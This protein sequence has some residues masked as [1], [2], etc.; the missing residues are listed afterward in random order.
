MPEWRRRVIECVVVAVLLVISTRVFSQI[1][2]LGP[3]VDPADFR[4]TEFATGLNF[5]VGMAELED[6]SILAAVS[7]DGSLFGSTSGSLVRL[8]DTDGDGIADE[9]STLVGNVPGG[10]LTTVRVAGDLVFTTGQGSGK[11]ISIYRFGAQLTD[12]LTHVGSLSIV[13][14]SGGWLHPHSTVAVREITGDP[15]AYELYFQLGSRT[16][17]ETT[18]DTATLNSTIGVSGS[19]AGDAIHRVTITDHGA[20]LT[21]DSLTQIATGL[22]NSAGFAFQPGTGDMFLQDNGIDGLSN[23]IEPHSADELNRIRRSDLGGEIE[24]FGFPSTYEQYRT[25]V[26]IGTTGIDPVVA[27]QPI[28]GS[29]SEGPNDIAFAPPAF[30]AALRNGIF[31]TMHGQFGSGGLLNEE[32]PLVFVDLTD[33]S[34]FHFIEN[35][36]PSVGHLDGLLSTHDSLFVADMSPSGRLGTS[37]AYTGKIY[38]IKSLVPSGDFNLDGDYTC[39]DIDLLITE[40]AASSNAVPFDL[41]RD[42]RVDLADR[43]AWLSEAGSQ[44][45]GPG[46]SYL[47]GDANLDGR[48]DATDVEIWTNHRFSVATGW[49]D[50][51]FQGDGFVDGRDFNLLLKNLFRVADSTAIGVPE[52]RSALL[53]SFVMWSCWGAQRCRRRVCPR[54]MRAIFQPCTGSLCND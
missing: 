22:R 37:S 48:V 33:N 39:E 46:A 12:P 38:Q 13:Y 10:G 52:P 16:N 20:S 34:Y 43:D 19:L 30:P 47:V 4:I 32:N 6:G 44:K 23:P 9:Q 17:F 15:G 42:G 28:D 3:G 49:C 21:A 18:T 29:E 41:T 14:P 36:E 31:V 50:G 26:T 2:L 24:N 27:F 7:N 40:I 45:L 35:T 5:P 54:R 25:G 8:V 51:D 53:F 11:P 1:S